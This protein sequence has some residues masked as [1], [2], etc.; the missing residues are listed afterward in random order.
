LSIRI[1]FKKI[2]D[3]QQSVAPAPW[4]GHPHTPTLLLVADFKVMAALREDILTDNDMHKY[5][6]VTVLERGTSLTANLF[7]TYVFN[8]AT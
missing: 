3:H 5:F 2:S 7:L 6:D 1:L 4:R 8:V